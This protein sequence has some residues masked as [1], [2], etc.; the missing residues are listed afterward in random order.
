MPINSFGWLAGCFGIMLRPKNSFRRRFCKP[1]DRFTDLNRARTCAHG[2]GA[3]GH[4]EAP[5]RNNRN[6]RCKRLESYSPGSCLRRLDPL[7]RD[8]RR[9]YGFD[10][11]L[12][13]AASQSSRSRRSHRPD[14]AGEN[15]I[16]NIALLYL[17]LLKATVTSFSGLD[18]LPVIRQDLIVTHHVGTTVSSMLLS[19]WGVQR[20]VG[21]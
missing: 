5:G 2:P 7:D 6:H 14:M 13:D 1:G 12:F 10:V 11:A 18:P 8:R 19:R 15:A 17:L 3:D 16:M 9:R 21:F 20:H 4:T